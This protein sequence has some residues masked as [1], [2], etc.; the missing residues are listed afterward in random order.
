MYNSLLELQRLGDKLV[1]QLRE[2]KS[3]I[4]IID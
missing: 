1:G 3:T 2:N 4:L